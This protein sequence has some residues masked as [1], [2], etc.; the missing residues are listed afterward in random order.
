MPNYPA[1]C[2]RPAE[3][4]DTDMLAPQAAYE[5]AL[6]PVDFEQAQK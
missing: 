1:S 2:N 4:D 6:M 5:L 3:D